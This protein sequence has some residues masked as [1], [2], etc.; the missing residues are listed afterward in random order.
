MNVEQREK[1]AVLARLRV[2]GTNAFVQKSGAI[3]KAEIITK[4][5]YKFCKLL[6]K[7][8]RT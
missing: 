5:G 3:D 7:N 6:F 8:P 1:T 4:C 2:R